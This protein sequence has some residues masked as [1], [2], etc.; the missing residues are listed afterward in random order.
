M[1]KSKKTRGIIKEEITFNE[2]YNTM[3]KNEKSIGI[4]I[5]LLAIVI[6]CSIAKYFFDR[7]VM[8]KNAET[9][10]NIPMEVNVPIS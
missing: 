2:I 5:A 1:V 6:C 4:V 9:N 10:V 8:S 7:Y 3:T